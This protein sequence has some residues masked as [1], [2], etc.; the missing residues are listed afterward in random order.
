MAKLQ[1]HKLTARQ[2]ATLSKPGWHGD[3][4]GLYLRISDDGRKRW[5]FVF[6]SEKRR[7]EMGLGGASGPYGVTLADAR[8]RTA[9]AHRKAKA[10]IDPLLDREASNSAKAALEA[11]VAKEAAMP[12]FGAF[13]DTY[14]ERMRPSWRNAK[15]ATQWVTTL[16]RECA[17][18]RERR[19]DCIGT[20]D[21]LEV[22]Q[23]LWSKRPETAQRLRGRIE[24]VLDAA[25][26]KGHRTGENPARWRGH[27]DNLLPQRQ[28]L[29]RGHHAALDYAQMP[30]F[31]SALRQ[32]DGV[33]ARL[34]E[35]IVLTAARSGEARGARWEEFDFERAEWSIPARR[36]KAG[37]PHRVPL[38]P[39]ALFIVKDMATARTGP[40]VFPGR[41]NETMSHMATANLLKRMGRGNVTT[42]GFRSAFRDWAAEVSTFPH[43]VCE[44]ALAH[45]I[46]NK[47]EAAYRRG[48]LFEKR[49]A[50]MTAWAA[51]C[52]PKAANVIPIKR[53][54]AK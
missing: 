34:L 45:A 30:E 48:D 3:G 20:E 15:H 5:V 10:G 26:A 2:V 6:F 16:T 46:V 38:S 40:H 36:M 24:N 18:I 42:H 19:V 52:E 33:A 29:T 28:K 27:L 37:K 31:M 54:K 25:K 41:S 14:V 8:Q 1:I 50:L 43:E 7:R 17:P 12:T 11:S 4:G 51:H 49:R 47:A 13:A 39:R 53:P 35:F 44:M 21:V 23:P 32:R 9:E 22:L